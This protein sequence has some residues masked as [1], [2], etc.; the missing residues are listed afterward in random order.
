[1]NGPARAP[2]DTMA[3]LARVAPFDRL[4]ANELAVL[5][6]AVQVR[7]FRPAAEVHADGTEP[8]RKLLVVIAG[9]VRDETGAAVGPVHGLASLFD[10]RPVA[11]L[12]ADAST[13]AEVITINRHTFFTLAHECPELVRGFLDLGPSG[14]SV[15]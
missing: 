3:A 13:G 4:R 6:E 1:M 15:T 5:A 10:G 8:P 12:V 7:A 2:V 11:R 14:A 9:T